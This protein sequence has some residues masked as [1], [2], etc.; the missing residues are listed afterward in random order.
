MGQAKIVLTGRQPPHV[1]AIPEG[2]Y[3]LDADLVAR[4]G[5]H[6][7]RDDLS[8]ELPRSSEI[9]AGVTKDDKARELKSVPDNCGGVRSWDVR[10]APE[11][12]NENE[13]LANLSLL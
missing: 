7:D 9:V 12:V 10:E 6:A 2:R 8:G 5:D 13:T 11:P 4:R 3:H 1:N